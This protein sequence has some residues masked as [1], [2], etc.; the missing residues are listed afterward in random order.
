MDR[1]RAPAPPAPRTEADLADAADL[2][3]VIST[4]LAATPIDEHALRCSVWTYVD[5][6][7]SAGASPREV[8]TALTGLVD[9]ARITPPAIRQALLRQLILWCVEAYFGCLGGNALSARAMS[10]PRLVSNR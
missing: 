2:R 4:V 10:G 3:S 6:E 5:T 8:I 9:A 1:P 7:R